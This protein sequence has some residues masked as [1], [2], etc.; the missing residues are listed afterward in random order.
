[1]KLVSALIVAV[2]IASPAMKNYVAFQKQR[3]SRRGGTSC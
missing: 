2:A 3:A 1:M